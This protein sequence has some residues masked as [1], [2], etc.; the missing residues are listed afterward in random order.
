MVRRLFVLV[1][2]SLVAVLGAPLTAQAE[3]VRIRDARGDMFR[4]DTP[5]RNDGYRAA[6]RQRRSD[7]RNVS[8]RHTGRRLVVRAKLAELQ[9]TGDGS[10]LSMRLRTNERRWRGV[11][12]A[13]GR[14][15]AG[16]W[17]GS[18]LM[19]RRN[20]TRVDCATAHDVDYDRNVMVV[21]I[22]RACLSDPRWV[23]GTVISMYVDRG[24]SVYY[25]NALHD[26]RNFGS[27]SERVRRG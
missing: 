6:P 4:D 13:V 9:R 20:G 11:H 3:T 10:A 15:E 14:A 5:R 23:Q 27:W 12:L 24:A 16:R 21:R 17:R 7:I 22:P 1:V 26:R 8:F 2:V 18:V 19:F 25:D